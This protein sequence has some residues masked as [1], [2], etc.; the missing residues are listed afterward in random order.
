MVAAE[1]TVSML[2]AEAAAATRAAAWAGAVQGGG[3]CAGAHL[4]LLLY[5]ARLLAAAG[6]QAPLFPYVPEVYHTLGLVL[7][8]QCKYDDRRD[9]D[10]HIL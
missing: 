9:Q 5:L 6:R 4:A 2:R 1:H 10:I 8:L 3:R 7:V